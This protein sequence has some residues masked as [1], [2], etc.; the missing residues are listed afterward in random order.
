MDWQYTPYIL[1]LLLGAMI[2]LGLAL[3]A[4]RRRTVPGAVTFIVLALA[5]AG[6][7]LGYSLEILSTDLTGKLFW[8]RLQYFGIAALPVAWMTFAL[9]YTRRDSWLTR[10]NLLL[11]LIIPI[12]TILL[13]WTNDIHG[14]IWSQVVLDTSGP[15]PAMQ[16]SYG[17]W[18]WV[19][20]I[21]AYLLLLFGTVLLI[22]MVTT[23]PDLYR[24]QAIL[25]L[26]GAI[27]PWFGNVAYILNLTRIPNLDLTPFAFSL[28]GV[29]VG[30]S[31]FRLR[32][33]DIMPVARR[34]VVDSMSDAV[35]VLDRQNRI[36]DLNPAAGRLIESPNSDAVGRTVTQVLS[37]WAELLVHCRD[38]TESQAELVK[39]GTAGVQHFEMQISPLYDRQHRPTGRLIVLR[40]ITARKAADE[41]LHES[42]ERFRQVVS[43]LSDHVYTT[44]FT[45]DGHQTNLFIA[46]NVEALTGYPLENFT[47]DWSFWPKK[48]IHPEDRAAAAAQV[49]RFAQ[50]Q[51][52]EMEYRMERADGQIIWVRDSGQVRMNPDGQRWVVFGV[53]SDITERKEAE[54]ALAQVRDQALEAS[55]LKSQFL[56]T[57]SHEFRTP[58][59]AVLGFSEMLQTGVYGPLSDKQ[60]SITNKIIGSATDLT[61]LVNDILDQ[62]HLETGKLELTVCRL[63]PSDLI[64]RLNSTMSSLAES[65]GLQ[66]ITSI[67]DNMP[68]ILEGDAHR[69][70][71]ILT[72]LVGNALKFTEQ[73]RVEVSFF[74]SNDTHWAM[75]VADTGPGIPAE[76]QQFI[77]DPFRQVDSSTTRRYGGSGL[78]L[79]IT[80]RLV[81]LMGGQITVE[82]EPEQGSTFTVLLPLTY[83]R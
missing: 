45:R 5:V 66:L 44:E 6:W 76:A 71:Q 24:W 69:L 18:F 62:A 32:F 65:K 60:L 49:E 31:L 41:A 19:Q 38:Q 42:E 54:Q 9:Q 34:T 50:G 51:N 12:I 46:P 70:Y 22:R 58:L 11:L 59:N 21:Y 77:F 83:D 40:D 35:I 30:W 15:F 80:K 47:A 10:R 52:S 16:V 39:Y 17:A 4:W 2:S 8:A 7:C 33:F 14:L 3:Y 25:L 64:T 68:A 55:R 28:S 56:A 63:A 72:Y 75:Q 23:F 82:S 74:R 13:V 61:L 53:V 67:N 78:G 37:G 20:W 36:V 26:F 27:V 29:A 48:V 81:T 1:L 43:S 73:G 79:A 57:V